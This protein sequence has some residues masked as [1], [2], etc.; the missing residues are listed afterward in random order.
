[1]DAVDAG[2]THEEM[3]AVYAKD[4]PMQRI[5]LPEH[6]AAAVAYLLSEPAIALTGWIVSPN[7]GTTRL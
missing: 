1:M 2:L 5:N 6:Q 3:V 7:G 4:S